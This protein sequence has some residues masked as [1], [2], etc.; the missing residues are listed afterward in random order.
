MISLF[1]SEGCESL[2]FARPKKSNQ[3]K[4]RP[5]IW[6][7]RDFPALLAFIGAKINSLRSNKFLLNPMKAAMLGCIEGTKV[8][9]PDSIIYDV[10]QPRHPSLSTAGILRM[11]TQL[12][13]E[14][15]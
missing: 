5:T 15:N 9:T 10:V 8:K 7:L 12:P 11:S 3:K 6:S 1:L 2:F 13:P 14:N 4:G